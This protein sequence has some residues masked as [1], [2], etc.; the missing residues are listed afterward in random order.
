[1]MSGWRCTRQ[2]TGQEGFD[3][4]HVAVAADGAIAQGPASESLVT[5]AVVFCR[6]GRFV[7]GSHDAEQAAAGG[8]AGCPVAIG[9]QAVAA[10]VLEAV[11]QHVQQEAADE[12]VSLEGHGLR[13]VGVFIVFPPEGDVAVVEADQPVVRN[14]DAMGIAAQVVEHVPGVAE[15]RLRVD[16][17]L[18]LCGRREKGG[19]CLNVGERSKLP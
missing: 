7:R 3:A 18:G 11:G 15:R 10:D 14:G 2:C 6:V 19:E 16:H 17:P 13:C 8:E 1:M 5:V 4:D 9:Q 12:F